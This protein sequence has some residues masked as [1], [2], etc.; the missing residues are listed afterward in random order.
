[1]NIPLYQIGF[2]KITVERVIDFLPYPFLVA[3][4]KDNEPTTV[5]VNKK[6]NEEIGFSIEEIPTI[7]AWF[8]KAYPQAEYRNEVKRVWNEMATQAINSNLN[9]VT[10]KASVHT[11]GGGQIWYDIKSSFIGPLHFV[12][13]VNINDATLK[14]NDLQRLNENKNRMLS[15]LSHDLRN[16]LSSLQ[17]LIQLTLTQALTSEEFVNNVETLNNKIFQ[18][19]EFVDTTLHWTK[20]NFDQFKISITPVNLIHISRS[21]LPVYETAYRIKNITVT[22]SDEVNKH[23]ATDAEIMTIVIRNL[24]SNAIKFTPDNGCIA[25]D[26]VQTEEGFKFTIA[27]T[28]I[29]MTAQTIHNILKDQYTSNKGTREEKGLGIGLKLCRDLLRKVNSE[30]RIQSKVGKGTTMEILVRDVTV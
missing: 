9:S 13:F 16:P 6:F 19:V 3:E 7:D 18:L 14:E 10:M 2:E 17:T 26:M 21:I 27:D 4:V 20:S 25:I 28:G 29:G 11:K 30:L 5:F 22:V 15:I 12:A 23:I 1:M 8:L 24:L